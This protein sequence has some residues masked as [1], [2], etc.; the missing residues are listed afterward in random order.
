MSTRQPKLR[1]PDAQVP[2]SPS[3]NVIEAAEKFMAHRPATTA[4]TA[5]VIR[6][7]FRSGQPKPAH[8]RRTH[9]PSLARL[10]FVTMKGRRRRAGARSYWNDVPTGNGRDDFKRGLRYAALAVEAMTADDAP[11]YLERILEAIVLD[12][13]SRKASGGK[14]SRTLP[15]AADGF[16]YELSRRFSVAGSGIAPAS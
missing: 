9:G 2:K 3:A 8:H 13:A 15:P 11:W 5:S 10:P 4:G 14:H 6:P 12:A 16:I 1:I 7:D